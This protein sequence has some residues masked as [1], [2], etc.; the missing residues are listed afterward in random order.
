MLPWKS[1]SGHN[2]NA[3]LFFNPMKGSCKP[4]SIACLMCQDVVLQQR[5]EGV[6]PQKPR[7]HLPRMKQRPQQLLQVREAHIVWF[8][9]SL[10]QQLLGASHLGHR[11]KGM[12]EAFICEFQDLRFAEPGNREQHNNESCDCPGGQQTAHPPR[13]L[14]REDSQCRFI[15][16]GM[17]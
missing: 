17:I 14:A 10:E 7:E 6:Q 12:H 1:H 5:R 9:F 3:S 16:D 4:I 8:C 11:G 2:F 15:S 13:R